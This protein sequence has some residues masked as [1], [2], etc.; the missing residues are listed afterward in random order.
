MCNLLSPAVLLSADLGTVWGPGTFSALTQLLKCLHAAP[1]QSAQSR[2][3]GG[4]CRAR[5]A[6][7]T[8][9]GNQKH[10]INCSHSVFLHVP[11]IRNISTFPV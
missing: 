2:E 1:Q 7:N 9:S 6:P 5:G 10:A 8:W 4:V 11:N 3:S